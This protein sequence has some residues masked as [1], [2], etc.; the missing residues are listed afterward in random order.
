MT[1]W[2]CRLE[3]CPPCRVSAT[4][5]CPTTFQAK[6][7][8]TSH[9][10]FSLA[11]FFACSHTNFILDA[12]WTLLPVHQER[13]GAWPGR[14]LLHRNVGLRLRSPS[15]AVRPHPLLFSSIKLKL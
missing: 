2:K 13:E 8:I 5:F 6:P 4:T 3:I 14:L 7:A 1:A 9:S 10:L 15:D 12:A 11:T